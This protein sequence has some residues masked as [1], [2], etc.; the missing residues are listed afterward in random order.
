MDSTL[1]GMEPT[2]AITTTSTAATAPPPPETSPT[3]APRKP[4]FG[5]V[6]LKRVGWLGLTA[7]YT[8]GAIMT[9]LFA[10]V[11]ELWPLRMLLT[12]GIVM[13]GVAAAAIFRR[14][15]GHPFTVGEWLF[16]LSIGWVAMIG[17]PII[18]AL[19]FGL[20]E[21]LNSVVRSVL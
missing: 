19:H 21:W 9:V 6:G 20:V 14:R 10:L 3:Q 8:Y 11:V 7:A 2:T 17:T 13:V 15:S 18:F 1:V 4:P 12:A 5:I 16:G